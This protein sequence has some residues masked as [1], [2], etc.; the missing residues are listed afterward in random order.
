[1]M[2]GFWAAG[3]IVNANANDWQTIWLY[4]AAFAAVIMLVFAVSFR[5]ENIEYQE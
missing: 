5:N 3:Q 4:P 2:I 1:M